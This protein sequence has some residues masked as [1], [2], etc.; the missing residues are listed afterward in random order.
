MEVAICF[1][2]FM[3][4]I[5]G[6]KLYYHRQYTEKMFEYKND[7]I[8]EI[9]NGFEKENQQLIEENQK[10][11]EWVKNILDTFGTME[12]RE[13]SI[14]IPVIKETRTYNSDILGNYEEETIIIPEIIV[15][16]STRR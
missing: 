2:V 1:L 7:K 4:F 5:L 15:T 8:A 6:V 3:V 16:K 9:K 11:I 12:V 13:R 10:M 14:Q